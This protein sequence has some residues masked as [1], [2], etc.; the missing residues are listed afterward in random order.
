MKLLEMTHKVLM[1]HMKL[2]YYKENNFTRCREI[3]FL[4]EISPM[5]TAAAFHVGL[6]KIVT[7]YRFTK[8]TFYLTFKIISL[9]L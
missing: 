1:S 2:F 8:A 3:N 5:C 7:K 9:R 4:C 6:F